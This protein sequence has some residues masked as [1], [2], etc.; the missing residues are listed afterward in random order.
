MLLLLVVAVPLLERFP[1]TD[2]CGAALARTLRTDADVTKY[3]R[4]QR[5]F[6][7]ELRSPR[8]CTVAGGCVCLWRL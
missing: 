2:A 7:G 1:P 5:R 4:R 8:R 3:L 6:F